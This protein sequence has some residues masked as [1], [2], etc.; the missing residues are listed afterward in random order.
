MSSPMQSPPPEL[1]GLAVD[2]VDTP[3]GQRMALTLTI[4]FQPATAK[5]IA[6]ALTQIAASMSQSGRLVVANGT[7]KP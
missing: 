6:G 2:V 1:A 5:D 7:V 4:H 3:N